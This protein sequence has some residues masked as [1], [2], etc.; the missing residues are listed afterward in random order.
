MTERIKQTRGK[1]NIRERAQTERAETDPKGGERAQKNWTPV[2]VGTNEI[3]VYKMDGMKRVNFRDHKSRIF[4]AANIHVWKQ[5]INPRFANTILVD[6]NT[7]TC[8]PMFDASRVITVRERSFFRRAGNI[9]VHAFMR[10]VARGR[11][12]FLPYDCRTIY[13]V[14]AAIN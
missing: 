10:R 6:F 4:S 9:P 2:R 8:T 1:I 7:N 3:D 5:E 12:R 11:M 13:P 14:V